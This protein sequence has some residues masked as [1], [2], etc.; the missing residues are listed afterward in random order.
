MHKKLLELLACV[1]CSLPRCAAC[2]PWHALGSVAMRRPVRMSGM[3]SGRAPEV[4]QLF[5]AMRRT[6]AM[7]QL[8]EHQVAGSVA[9]M[10]AARQACPAAMQAA[11]S[12]VVVRHLQSPSRL[13]QDCA[14]ILALGSLARDVVAHEPGRSG[15]AAMQLAQQGD[16]SLSWRS[17]SAYCTLCRCCASLSDDMATPAAE[18]AYCSTTP[19]AHGAHQF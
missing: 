10:C 16:Q 9:T 7:A 4:S 12:A 19:I 5:E 2:P 13:G 1:Y 18:A 17:I 15:R 6:A 11:A 8:A 3:V 14:D